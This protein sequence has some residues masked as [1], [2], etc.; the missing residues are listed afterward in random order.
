MI[1]TS[2]EK[3]PLPSVGTPS[4]RKSSESAQPVWVPDAEQS[5]GFIQR[6]QLVALI[7]SSQF[8]HVEFLM[9]EPA[10]SEVS[11]IEYHVCIVPTYRFPA[12]RFREFEERDHATVVACSFEELLRHKFVRYR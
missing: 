7:P 6:R 11:A 5:R 2:A 8:H 3:F 9:A 4:E 1:V 10:L 12:G